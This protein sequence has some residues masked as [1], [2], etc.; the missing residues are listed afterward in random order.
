MEGDPRLAYARDLVKQGC[1]VFAPDAIGFG[2]RQKDH[3]HALYRS[4]D[5][6]FQAHP[7]GSVMAKMIY[8]VQRAIDLLEILPEVRAERVG[9]IG[10]S[11]GAYGTLFAMLFEPRIRAGVVS[12]ELRKSSLR[13]SPMTWTAWMS[14]PRMV[15]TST[16]ASSR[17]VKQSTAV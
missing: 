2:E 3:P 5:Q 12:C 4:A 15:N 16:P 14:S 6:F 9:C 11:H 13:G 17:P 1:L 10:H 7:C 8:D